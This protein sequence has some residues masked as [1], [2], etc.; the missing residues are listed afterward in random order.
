MEAFGILIERTKIEEDNK[1]KEGYLEATLN[2]KG[3]T[4]YKKG[5]FTGHYREYVYV[6]DEIIQ[7]EILNVLDSKEIKYKKAKVTT[8]IDIE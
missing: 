6:T 4:N 2:A 3:I 5:Y 7:T 1:Y 8:T